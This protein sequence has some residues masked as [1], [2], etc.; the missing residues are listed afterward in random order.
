MLKKIRKVLNN[1]QGFTLIEL[2]IVVVILGI[3][4]SI[5]TPRFVNKVGDAKIVKT[6]ADLTIIQNA[7]DLYFLDF[8]VYPDNTNQLVEAGYLH[9]DPVKVD[10]EDPYTI[11]SEDGS[12]S[13]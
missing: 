8:D 10:S 6:Q 5:A 9:S 4:A 2:M 13:D 11:D 1:E 7:V 12:V 3:L